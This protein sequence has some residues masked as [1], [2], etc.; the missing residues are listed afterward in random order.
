MATKVTLTSPASR[1][2]AVAPRATAPAQV[3]QVAPQVAQAAA[4]ATPAVRRGA[5]L[6]TGKPVRTADGSPATS[7]ATANLQAGNPTNPGTLAMLSDARNVIRQEVMAASV[8]PPIDPATPR[9]TLKTVPIETLGQAERER[10]MANIAEVAQAAKH[11]PA[12]EI[13]NPEIESLPPVPNAQGIDPVLEEALAAEARRQAS[14]V[15]GE[16]SLTQNLEVELREPARKPVGGNVVPDPTFVR[17]EGVDETPAEAAAETAAEPAGFCPYC[18]WDMSRPADPEPNDVEKLVYTKSVLAGRNYT[19]ELTLFDGLLTVRFRAL[20]TPELD[21]IYNHVRGERR[22]GLIDNELDFWE[23]INRYKMYLQLVRLKSDGDEGYDHEMPEGLTPRTN[24][25]GRSYWLDYEDTEGT[26]LPLIEE[27]V[28]GKVLFNETLF[29]LVYKA[30]LA[31][32]RDLARL[33]T[34]AGSA[35]FTKATA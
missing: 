3:A 28:Q 23:R 16:V 18:A 11:A 4:S 33:E 9:V 12:P 17:P 15:G 7:L 24:P 22:A 34:L 27:S 10:T 1:A 26:L 20:T 31:F 29:R 14:G 25:I 6:P 5:P 19:R 30:N 13:Q 2:P 21:K 8:R 35:S 32:N